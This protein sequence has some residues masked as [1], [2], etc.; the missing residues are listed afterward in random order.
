[1]DDVE[2]VRPSPSPF[3][4]HGGLVGGLLVL[5]LIVV[6]LKPWGAGP[7]HVA[8]VAVAPTAT[9]TPSPTASPPPDNGYSDVGYDPSIFGI[10]PPAPRWGIWP[11]GYLV[12][13]GFVA[14]VPDA[15]APASPGPSSPAA[16]LP[17]GSASPGSPQ[18]GPGASP[19]PV[20]TPAPADGGP[21]WQGRFEV[22]D[23]THLL[24]VG[25][26]MPTGFSLQSST[27]ERLGT[28]GTWEAVQ[29]DRYPPPWDHFAV[30]GLPRRESDG[31]LEPW[32]V[33]DYRLTVVFDPSGISRTIEIVV[34]ERTSTP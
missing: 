10:A 25:I 27:L 30:V 6:I 29:L 3:S 21:L 24:L 19:A 20:A 18:A 23:G 15:P 17:S 13:F 32:P 34:S 12:T 5:A 26:N 7:G 4:G 33:G 11:V 22:P 14:Q 2:P 31:H 1:M 8:S 9:P 16:T 28:T